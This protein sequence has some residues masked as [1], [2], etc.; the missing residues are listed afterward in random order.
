MRIV[1]GADG[2]NWICLQ[3]PARTGTPDGQVIV[4]C[5]SG[6]HRTEIEV[7]AGWDALADDDLLQRIKAALG[8]SA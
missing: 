8:R 7:P 1:T 6:A 2:T 5:N 3:V 4:E